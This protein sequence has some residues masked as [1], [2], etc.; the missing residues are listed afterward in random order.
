MRELEERLVVARRVKGLADVERHFVEAA[1]DATG[2][3]EGLRK[4][5]DASA[6]AV[7]AAGVAKSALEGE[8][9]KAHEIDALRQKSETLERHRQ[10]PGA[11]VGLGKE[12]TALGG[13]LRKAK[14]AFEEVER[15]HG[16]LAKQKVCARIE[17]EDRDSEGCV[18]R[19][20]RPE[21][22]RTEVGPQGRRRF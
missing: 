9:A 7:M 3:E 11:T 18:A 16:E 4:A 20:P 14:K 10:A 17:S 1:A 19:C 21:A 22:G 8:R 13:A 5:R 12:A 15:R 2:F 6:A